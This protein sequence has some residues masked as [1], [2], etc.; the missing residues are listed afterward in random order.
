[1][2]LS[3]P[4]ESVFISLPA[5]V[6]VVH[7]GGLLLVRSDR[8]RGGNRGLGHLLH[9]HVPFIFRFFQVAESE[10]RLSV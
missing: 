1:M 2:K 7:V 4:D 6:N 8:N 5:D 10:L 9:L 3:K